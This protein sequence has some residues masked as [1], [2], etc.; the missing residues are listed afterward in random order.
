VLNRRL[1]A[2]VSLVLFAAS[3][4]FAVVVAV[5][6]FPRRLSVLAC[7]LVALAAAWWAL[8]RRG[9]ARV[10]GAVLAAALLVGAVVLVVLESRV[11]ADAMSFA[12]LVVAVAAASRAFRRARAAPGWVAAEAARV[13]P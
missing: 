3:V 12:G 1:A 2:V 13:V 9:S 10:V 5:Q 11:P 8:V 4:V 7:E 6:S